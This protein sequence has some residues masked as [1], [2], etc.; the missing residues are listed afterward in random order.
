MD[1]NKQ[2]FRLDD[3]SALQKELNALILSTQFAPFSHC[4]ELHLVA[5]RVV[6]L[7]LN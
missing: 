7:Y 3:S 1:N 6:L 2:V 4:R 5:N